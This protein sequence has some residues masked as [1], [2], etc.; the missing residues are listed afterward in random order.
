L[1]NSS[2]P[3]ASIATIVRIPYADGI[4]DN[5]DYLYTFTDLGIFKSSHGASNYGNKPQQAPD[6]I[7]GYAHG[8][9]KS[10]VSGHHHVVITGPSSAREPRAGRWHRKESMELELVDKRDGSSGESKRDVEKSGDDSRRGES[11]SWLHV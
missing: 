8:R 6:G 4:L 1:A 11:P 2:L 10:H 7:T 9:S 3:S 5:P